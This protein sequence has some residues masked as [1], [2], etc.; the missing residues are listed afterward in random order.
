MDAWPEALEPFRQEPDRSVLI[1][2]YDGT[3]SPIV[4]DPA[5]AR[6]VDGAAELLAALAERYRT[7]AVVSG[8]SVDFL[9]AAAAR[10]PRAVGH[11]RPRADRGRPPRRPPVGRGVA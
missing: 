9:A 4:T 10:G 1:F 6:L 3:L 5:A 2:D 11:L 8:R 7:V